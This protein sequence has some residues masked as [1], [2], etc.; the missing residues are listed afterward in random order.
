MTITVRKAAEGVAKVVGQK[1]AAPHAAA[2]ISLRSPRAVTL[3]EA[4]ADAIQPARES[5]KTTMTPWRG[6]FERVLQEVIG[7]E[8]VKKIKDTMLFMPDDIYDLEQSPKPSQKIPISKTD[9]TITAM[10]RYPSPGSQESVRIPEFENGKDPYDTG[11]F[12]RDTRRRY[13]FEELGD[14]DIEK[15]KLEL[16]DPNDPQVQEDKKRVEAGPASSPGNKGVFATGPSDF[17]PTGL[18]ATMSVTWS[19]LNKSLDAHMPDHL[20][21]PTWMKD[22]EAIIAWHKERDLPVPVGPVYEGL[23]VPVYLRVARW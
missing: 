1:A 3:A 6:W 11:Y 22:K 2:K 16:M 19:E 8:R 20:P 10:Y 15:A 23:K 7:E 5:T 14:P 17:D 4:K 9:P 21:T 13:Q 12:K 18:R